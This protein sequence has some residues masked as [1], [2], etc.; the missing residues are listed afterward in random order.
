MKMA[1]L[2][3]DGCASISVSAALEAFNMANALYCHSRQL[4]EPLFELFT[5]SPDGN[6]VPCSGGLQLVPQYSLADLPPADLVMVPGYM[7]NVLRVLPQLDDLYDW[8]RR[9]HAQGSALASLCTG[10][11][12]NAEAGLLDGRQATTHW[13]FAG[14]FA[15]RYPKVQ[16]HAERTL[17]EDGHVYCSGGANSGGDLLL[18]LIRKYGSPQ[19][20][21]DC[22]KHLLIDGT[23]QTQLPYAS[24]SFKKQHGDGDI[25]NVQLW[26]ERHLHESI[27]IEQLAEQFNIGQRH[28]I[29]RFKDATG[30]TP[31]H[32][33]QNLRL[34]RARLLLESSDS[35]FDQITLQVG[36][37]D[38]NSFR[39]LFKQRVGLTP[40]EYR[41]KFQCLM[42]L[43]ALQ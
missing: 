40:S 36:Y 18:H 42:P 5:A 21:A 3:S 19:L 2:M 9:V 20:A 31:I 35:A 25:L 13:A 38:H 17:T 11:F 22:G 37:D 7:F 33:L 28:F 14:Q 26:L 30:H 12:I 8:L 23:Q 27:V 1:I 24:A 32:Y 15:R 43:G 39:R 10:A 4:D 16:L 6:A 34:E 29:R 41:K